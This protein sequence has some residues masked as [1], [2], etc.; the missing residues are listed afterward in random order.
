MTESQTT[1]ATPGL[2]GVLIDTEQQIKLGHLKAQVEAA[3]GPTATDMQT[4]A[5]TWLIYEMGIRGGRVQTCSVDAIGSNGKTLGDW[6]I[7]IRLRQHEPNKI[8][9]FRRAY[10]ARDGQ[11][12]ATL[13]LESF[14]SLPDDNF[15]AF[16]MLQAA[17][18]CTSL[19]E[20]SKTITVLDSA[21]IERIVTIKRSKR[22][23]LVTKIQSYGSSYLPRKTRRTSPSEKTPS[24]KIN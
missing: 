23:T 13:A 6:R 9:I 15:H 10:I 16:C 3:M 5:M 18:F 12:I 4:L 17:E 22:S 1:I 2:A 11:E 21:G 19:Q 20:F 7:K 24:L 14:K 8:D